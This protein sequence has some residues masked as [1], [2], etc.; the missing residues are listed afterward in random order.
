MIALQ[1]VALL[2]TGDVNVDRKRKIGKTPQ[3]DIDGNRL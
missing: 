3:S 1:Q 2:L